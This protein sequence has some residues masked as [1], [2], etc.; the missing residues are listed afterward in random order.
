MNF[1]R[2]KNL[3]ILIGALASAALV[4]PLIARQQTEPRIIEIT[5]KRHTFEPAVVEVVLGEPV[6]FVVKS[7]DVLHGFAIKK[8]K[9]DKDVPAGG[10]VKI[11]FV[12][13]EAGEFPIICSVTCGE[14]HATMTGMLKVVVKTGGEDSK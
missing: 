11:D 3:T 1:S 7:T 2:Q 14:G 4:A 9:I 12:A 5:A 6:R 10:D 13:K 8:F